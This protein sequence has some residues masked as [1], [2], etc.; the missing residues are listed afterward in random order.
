[1]P[2][3][4]PAQAQGW[5][6]LLDLSDQPSPFAAWSLVGGQ[7]TLLHATAAG[8]R[9]P[10]PTLD[11]DVVVDLVARPGGGEE[12]ARQMIARGFRLHG[13]N[14]LGEIGHRFVRDADPGPGQ[15]IIDLLAPEGLGARAN[16]FTVRPARTVE[17]PGMRQALRRTE[18]VRV[19]IPD[20]D[21]TTRVGTV[22]RPSL[23]G[24]LVAKACAAVIPGRREPVR[25]WQDLAVLL[26]CVVD[27]ITLV[28]AC[29]TKDRK[30]L[31]RLSELADN[32]HPAWRALDR[33]D[34]RN[35]Q[36]A[37][38]FLLDRPATADKPR[39]T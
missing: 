26:A 7:L 19:E 24:A 25:D 31:A 13:I 9:K 18:V 6:L 17:S 39:Q 20:T 12:L 27:P 21:G 35:G 1:M 2:D 15:V 11:I 14:P 36:D 34:R 3:M 29:D 22:R 37:L 16:L 33:P 32:D 10:R 38:R 5:R 4:P 28:D 23:L 30:R 8:I